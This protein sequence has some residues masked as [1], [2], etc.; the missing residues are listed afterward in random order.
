MKKTINRNKKAKND[1]KPVRQEVWSESYPQLFTG[2]E[3][4]RRP[5]DIIG[6]GATMLAW[7]QQNPEALCVEEF[8]EAFGMPEM[9]YYRYV[10]KFPK[11]ADHH[12]A[13]LML[14]ANR[15]ERGMVYLKYGMRDKPLMFVH[16]YYRKYWREEEKRQSDLKNA[17]AMNMP[18]VIN[19][20]KGFPEEEKEK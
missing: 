2:D 6:I 15:R 7:L 1:T 8:L 12:R 10:E 19:V 17:E 4:R 5:S 13:A 3:Q 9:S 20:F 16:G 11:L 18:S 14:L